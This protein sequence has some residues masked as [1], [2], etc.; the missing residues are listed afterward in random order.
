RLPPRPPPAGRRG[1]ARRRTTVRAGPPSGLSRDRRSGVRALTG[2]A[3]RSAG[4]QSGIPHAV[5]VVPSSFPPSS[6]SGAQAG[7]QLV[8]RQGRH[9]GDE[10][11][12]ERGV[13]VAPAHD[14]EVLHDRG[15]LLPTETGELS[16]RP[17]GCP[18]ASRVPVVVASGLAGPRVGTPD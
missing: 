13:R 8:G 16:P 2:P 9:L 15:L 17:P 3:G 14:R 10:L 1:S 18:Q 5:G 4:S 11:G 6:R 7:D 12:V